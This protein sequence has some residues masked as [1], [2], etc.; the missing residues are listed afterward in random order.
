[1]SFSSSQVTWPI[2]FIHS[3]QAESAKR[4]SSVS[5][6]SPLREHQHG[7][8]KKTADWIVPVSSLKSCYPSK[9]FPE[10]VCFVLC[11][12]VLVISPIRPSGGRKSLYSPPGFNDPRKKR[13]SR[14][15]CHHDVSLCGQV[16]LGVLIYG[17]SES[18]NLY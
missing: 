3:K 11:P 2:L 8:S 18:V 1:M 14:Y 7:P 16:I 17:E 6:C 9:R 5:R 13:R 10:S 15:R 4:L 12:T